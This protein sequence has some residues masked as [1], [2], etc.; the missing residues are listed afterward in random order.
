LAGYP[1]VFHLGDNI[2]PDGIKKLVDYFVKNK[3]NGLLPV[4]HHQD[5]LRMGVPLFNKAGKLIKYVEK[6]KSAPHD[7]AVPGLYFADNNFFKSFKG[8]DAVKPSARGE[9][10]IPDPFQWMIDHG[11]KVETMKIDGLWLDPGKFDDW[12]STNQTLLDLNTKLDINSKV[13]KNSKIEGRVKIG[14]HCIIKNSVIRGPVNITDNVTA[15]NSF[16][17]PYTSIASGCTIES[18]N[19]QNCE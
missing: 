19:N 16:I 13:D 17:G 12:L 4:V 10:E 11:L 5:N 6:P 14:R 8:K 1:F 3:P 15:I 2:F 7:L 18:C 9:W